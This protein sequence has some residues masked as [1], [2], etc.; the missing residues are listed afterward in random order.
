MRF[1][2]VGGALLFIS[3][4]ALF[5]CSGGDAA[6][7]TPEP[8]ASTDASPPPPDSGPAPDAAPPPDDGGSGDAHSPEDS[9]PDSSNL[10]S[11]TLG[12]SCSGASPSF[13]QKVQPIF[14]ASCSGENC[15]NGTTNPTWPYSKL[16]NV[17]VDVSNEPCA[18]GKVRVSPGSLADSYLIN[19]LTGIDMC[20]GT[21]Q[22]PRGGTMLPASDLQAI[23][24]WICEGA[25]NN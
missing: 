20:P 9:G 4:I 25:K 6:P 2:S 5:A 7:P 10:D 1:A 19:K 11:S 21:A 14:Q 13:A 18:T 8:D 17:A 23:A 22:M 3:S 16:V 15:H 12:V 24:D